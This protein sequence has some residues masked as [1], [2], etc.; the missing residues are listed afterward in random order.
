MMAAIMTIKT[1]DATIMPNTLVILGLGFFLK[2]N[3]EKNFSTDFIMGFIINAKTALQITG[4]KILTNAE[5]TDFRSCHW[6][7]AK[8]KATV[9]TIASNTYLKIRLYFLSENSFKSTNPFPIFLLI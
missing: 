1:I 6:N 4:S 3:L 2:I 7:I 5:N 9:M 8:I